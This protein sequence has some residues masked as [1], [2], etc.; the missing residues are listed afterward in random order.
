MILLENR[1]QYSPTQDE[2]LWTIQNKNLKPLQ[3]YQSL[4]TLV[5]YSVSLF[6]EQNHRIL[7]SLLLPPKKLSKSHIQRTLNLAESI[8]IALDMAL[9]DELGPLQSSLGYLSG[10][11]YDPGSTVKFK[12]KREKLNYY[13]LAMR[14]TYLLLE[15]YDKSELT[16]VLPKLAPELSTELSTHAVERALK[17]DDLFVINTNRMW[18]DRNY[19]IIRDFFTKKS[20]K[21][22]NHMDIQ[23]DPDHWVSPYLLFEKVLS[24]Y[25]DKA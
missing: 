20:K 13:H 8:V 5:S 24:V 12:S 15:G 25:F 1:I 11:L 3:Q 18:Q 17:L 9:G 10:T 7:W 4:Q 22:K 16:K 14:S 19:K 2:I 6:H 23:P 21:S